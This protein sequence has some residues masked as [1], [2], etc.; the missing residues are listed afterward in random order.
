MFCSEPLVVLPLDT[1][2]PVNLFWKTCGNIQI[3]NF[4]EVNHFSQAN[5]S[6][7]ENFVRPLELI[8]WCSFHQWVFCP[9]NSVVNVSEAK[10][11]FI[12]DVEMYSVGEILCLCRFLSPKRTGG[13][14]KMKVLPSSDQQRQ[15]RRK[16]PTRPF[17]RP[18]IAAKTSEK[19]IRMGDRLETLV[20]MVSLHNI[21]P[22]LSYGPSLGTGPLR[23]TRAQSRI[24]M[25]AQNQRMFL[26]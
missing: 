16:F 11:A 18:E 7:Y 10:D 26:L 8:Y 22:P 13:G 4:S 24:T 20:A 25:K 5:M 1:E 21:A 15:W 17:L 9:V 2:L 19:A 3:R 14:W 12:F 6:A 23:C